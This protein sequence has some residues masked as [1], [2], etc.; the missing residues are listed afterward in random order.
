M[1]SA[2]IGSLGYRVVLLV[3]Q[4]LTLLV[5]SDRANEVE[6]LVLRHQVSVLRR[7]VARPD[8]VPADRVMLAALSRLAAS[9]AVAD[10]LHHPSHAAALAP[11]PGR[12]AVDVSASSAGPAERRRRD[13]LAGV[14]VGV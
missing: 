3:L 13:P 14:A 9:V 6:I 5:R 4:F 2:V 8:L 12:P 10:V 11:R 7:Q 1:L